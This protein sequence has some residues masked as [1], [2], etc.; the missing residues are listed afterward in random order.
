MSFNVALLE[1]SFDALRPQATRLGERFYAN[2]FSTYPETKPLF[3]NTDLAAQQQKL[4][5]SLALVIDNLRNP[6][7]LQKTLYALGSRHVDYGTVVAHYPLV[8]E[9]LLETLAELMGD[10]WTPAH[11]QAW[12]DA[13]TAVSSLMI[14][15]ARLQVA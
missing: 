13:Y 1:T 14:E 8:G 2:L 10:Q 9:V 12:A 11:R 15:G 7:A 3:A 5:A 4:V 6:D